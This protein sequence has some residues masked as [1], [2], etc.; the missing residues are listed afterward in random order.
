[1]VIMKEKKQKKFNFVRCLERIDS[2]M[3][4][5]EKI[6]DSFDKVYR[7]ALRQARKII[8]ESVVDAS[9]QDGTFLD[10]VAN[11]D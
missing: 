1:M 10:I 2:L 6:D 9:E 5:S 3:S 4:T 7:I 11:G 8:Q